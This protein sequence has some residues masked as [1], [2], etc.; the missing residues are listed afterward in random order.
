MKTVLCVENDVFV[1]VH[2]RNLEEV[3]PA[4]KKWQ[5]MHVL[6]ADGSTSLVRGLFHLSF[7]KILV[8]T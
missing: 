8:S 4:A 6:C 2:K 3:H 7:S 1:Y 5:I